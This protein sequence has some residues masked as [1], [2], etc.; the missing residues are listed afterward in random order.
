MNSKRKGLFG[1]LLVGLL[2]LICLFV[3]ILSLRHPAEKAA[4][5]PSEPGLGAEPQAPG[6]MVPDLRSS[7]GKIHGEARKNLGVLVWL[8]MSPRFLSRARTILSWM[9]QWGFECAPVRIRDVEQAAKPPASMPADLGENAWDLRDA[10]SGLNAILVVDGDLGASQAV[11]LKDYIMAGGWG[12]M[13]SPEDGGASGE[14]EGLLRLKPSCSATLMTPEE[15]Q[16]ESPLGAEE[17]RVLTSQPL[18]SGFDL[19]SWLE[20]TGPAG[21]VLYS[22][23]DQ[24]LPLLCF[25]RPELPVVRLV[26]F[27]EGGVVHWNFPMRPGPV[28]EEMELK[29]LL[30]D[31]LSW[32]WGRESWVKPLQKEGSVSGIVRTEDETV[33]PGA[34]LTAQVYSEWGEAIETLEATSSEEGEFSLS[35]LDPAIYWVKAKA[36]GYYQADMYLLTRPRERQDG[37]IEVLMEPEGAIFGHAYYGP[38]QDHPAIGISVALAPNCRISS[39]WEKETVTDRNARFSFD[40]LPAAQTSYLIAKAEGW[41][42][43]QEAPLPLDGGRLEIDVH[44]QSPTRIEGTTVNVVTQQPLPGV[45]IVTLPRSSIRRLFRDALTQRAVSDGEGKFTL[46]LL[47]GYWQYFEEAAGF[48]SLGHPGTGRIRV[49]D[50]G[51][52]EPSELRLCFCPAASLHGTVFRSS[53]EFTSGAKVTVDG[54]EYYADEK[55]EY[56]TDP[57]TPRVTQRRYAQFYVRADWNGESGSR[58]ATFSIAS[59]H[60]TEPVQPWMGHY[61]TLL[62]GGFPID[63]HLERS[64]PE[65]EPSGTTITGVVLDESGR[66]ASS[67]VVELAEPG[68]TRDDSWGF[69]VSPRKKTR[70]DPEGAFTFSAVKEGL[71]LIRAQKKIV[72]AWGKE[73]L[74]WGEKWLTVSEDTPVSG[75]QVRLEKAHV[76]GKVVSADGT[77]LRDRYASFELTFHTSSGQ[78]QDMFLGAAGDFDLCPRGNSGQVLT[79]PPLASYKQWADAEVKRWDP[80]AKAVIPWENKDLPPQGYVRL[81]LGVTAG[82]YPVALEPVEARL[83]EESLVIRFPATG[84][85]RGRVVDAR[86]GRPIAGARAIIQREGKSLPRRTT[87]SEGAFS[88]DRVPL[89][90]CDFYANAP[91]YYL[92]YKEEIEIVEGQEYYIEANLG[93][94]YIIR[95]RLRLKET[96]ERLLWAE[97]R[98]KYGS[99][100]TQDGTFAL[101]V[102]GEG[103][104]GGYPFT[105]VPTTLPG[106]KPGLK[107]VDV[108]APP[109]AS[110]EHEVDVG[111]IYVERE[112]QGGE[113]RGER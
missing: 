26:P 55:G 17:V 85:V 81:K 97:I 96:G 78:R 28:I 63:V 15:P 89:G 49:L 56:R 98:T 109:P 9:K 47:P 91:G 5:Q 64:Q 95:G 27:G 70:S 102:P 7:R 29:A 38:G 99:H 16:R 33:I 2:C 112:E 37:K 107:S 8:G 77:P 41:M 52:S 84:S 18:T 104:S 60:S 4:R 11:A 25:A 20:W 3:L 68:A 79:L 42:G 106:M 24:S 66:T 94:Y 43:L 71:W 30:G 32:L 23:T 72:E 36:E 65:P 93:T 100:V 10:S 34:K 6:Q 48:A 19:G 83:G 50:N 53:G 45:E 113:A 13:P 82:A 76:R 101:Q 110:G 46:Q 51:E 21:E 1:F 111:D 44:L 22:K 58:N 92:A 14:V 103:N 61:E 35:I 39:A 54:I 108:V 74:Y 87:D 73:S 86:T 80:E 88:F 57:M 31:T 90:P 75:L 12:I 67:A 69:W 62:T 105:V 59:V 40:H